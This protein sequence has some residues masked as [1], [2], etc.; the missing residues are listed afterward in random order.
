VCNVPASNF[1]PESA[2]VIEEWR[3]LT[4]VNIFPVEARPSVIR[5]H[6]NETW[7][8]DPRSRPVFCQWGWDE[9]FYLFV[10]PPSPTDTQVIVFKPNQVPSDLI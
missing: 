8:L 1:L 2:N 9:Y 6:V 7:W 5:R 4:R 3:T 10:L